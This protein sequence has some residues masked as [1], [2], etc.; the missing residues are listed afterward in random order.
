MAKVPEGQ[1]LSSW[2]GSGAV[3]FKTYQE[4]PSGGG[5]QMNFGSLSMPTS[6]LAHPTSTNTMMKT[7]AQSTSRSRNASR[8]ETIS[9]ALST[10][11]YT[12]LS[13]LHIILRHIADG[14]SSNSTGAP[15]FYISCAQVS[16]SG[17]GSKVPTNLVSF[18][19][20]Y[21][22]SDPGFTVNIYNSRGQY[23]P[24]GPAVFSC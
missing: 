10:L 13:L 20:A 23:Q 11:L 22:A 21:K 9:S 17:G 5:S 19:G 1:T 3:W 15:Q 7:R 18:P 24:A 12:G 16:V 6:L 4:M 14:K 2:D 8:P